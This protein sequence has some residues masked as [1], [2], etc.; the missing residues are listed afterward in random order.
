MFEKYK[1]VAEKLAEIICNHGIEAVAVGNKILA[2]DS[3]TING[4]GY[5]KSITLNADRR[6]VMAW[7]GY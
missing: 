4:V 5:T 2:A 7:L 1:T 3:Y 6:E